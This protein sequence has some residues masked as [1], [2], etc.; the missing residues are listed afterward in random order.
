MKC[1]Y[2]TVFF[3]FTPFHP[4]ISILC[5]N[6]IFSDRMQEKVCGEKEEEEREKK[7]PLGECALTQSWLEKAAQSVIGRRRRRR[8]IRLATC[9]HAAS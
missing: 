2:A 6:E 8:V 3:F 9:A 7:K 1:V 5:R 4:D